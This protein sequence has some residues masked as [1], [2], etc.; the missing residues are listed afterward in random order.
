M[1]DLRLVGVSEDGLR[2]VL[3]ADDDRHFAVP[4]DDRLRAAI[5]GS[6]SALG[7]SEARSDAGLRPAEIQARIRAGQTA[8][9]VA[10]AAGLPVERVRR[11]ES[12]V[13]AERE[14]IAALAQATVVRRRGENATV[15][16]LRDVVA[17]RLDARG[18]GASAR[19]WDAWRRD[20]GRWDVRLAF[21]AGTTQGL[22]MWVFDPVRRVL[23]A[24]DDEARAL[25]TDEPG[26]PGPR[27]AR[28]LSSVPAYGDAV[29]DVEADGGITDAYTDDV[30]MRFSPDGPGRAAP[31]RTPVPRAEPVR[32]Q[33]AAAGESEPAAPSSDTTET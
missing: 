9:E 5:R 21:G 20:D 19:A 27:A 13:L 17:E 14:H 24:A 33:R 6:L 26:P 23:T 12:P 11:Y 16:L 2:L 30:A 32:P 4:V 18:A 1:Q 15:P 29:Y 31:P 8:E 10:E 25:S 7:T 22:A 28:R 3:A